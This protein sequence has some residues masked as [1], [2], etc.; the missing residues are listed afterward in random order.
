MGHSDV[1]MW[2]CSHCSC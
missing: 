2:L 1:V